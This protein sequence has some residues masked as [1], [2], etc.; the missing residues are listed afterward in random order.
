MLQDYESVAH[1]REQLLT[2]VRTNSNLAHTVRLLCVA[3]LHAP[4]HAPML[5]Q[6]CRIFLLNSTSHC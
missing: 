3:P 6:L 4:L 1:D 2:N 5:T